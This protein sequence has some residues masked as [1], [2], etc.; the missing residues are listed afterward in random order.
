M[1]CER[2]RAAPDGAHAHQGFCEAKTPA[3]ELISA[4]YFD[5]PW[6]GAPQGGAGYEKDAPRSGASFLVENTGLKPVAL[7]V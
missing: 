5:R 6:G 7:C 2:K 3:A 4:G 1:P